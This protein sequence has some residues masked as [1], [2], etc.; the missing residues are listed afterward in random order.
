MELIKL[1][2]SES[3]QAFKL[4]VMMT[5]VSGAANG[6]L[7]GLINAGAMAVHSDT[8]SS[9]DFILFVVGLVLY[10]YSK[11]VSENRGKKVMEQ[12]MSK[13]RLRIYEKIQ[14]ASLRTIEALKPSEVI[15]KTSRNISQILQSSDSVIYGMQSLMMLIFCSIY[16]CIISPAAFLVVMAGVGFL[17]VLRYVRDSTRKQ[18]HDELI[19]R[20]GTQSRY[21]AD[22]IE[23]FKEVKV[24]H[25]KCQ[26]LFSTF[27]AAVQEARGLSMKIAVQFIRFRIVMQAAFYVILATVVFILPRFIDTFSRQVMESTSVVLFIVGYLSGFVE[28]I[29]VFA[30]TNAALKNIAELEAQLDAEVEVRPRQL[31]P[32]LDFEK[33][34]VKNLHFAYQDQAGE[35][36]FSVGPLTLEIER[37]EILFLTGGNGSGK[38]TLLKVLTGL[39]LPDAGE[40]TVDNVVIDPGNVFCLRELYSVIFTDFHL[41][42]SFYGYRDVDAARVN[43]L[44]QTMRLGDKVRFTDGAFST[45]NLSTGQRKRLAL[46]IALIEDRQIY[47][48]DEWAAD[49]DQYFRRYF[50]EGILHELKA[51]GKTV[52][53]VTHDEAYWKHADRVVKLDAGVVV[54]QERTAPPAI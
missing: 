10:L 52:I 12:A 1:F 27:A 53:A 26:D 19:V 46:I 16:L 41:F 9:R 30:R 50:Y 51:R 3:S 4:I 36:A 54:R 43:A 40:I 5:V 17:I 49:Q 13:Q 48:F 18:Q 20:E 38:S 7:V 37:G 24:N 2:K 35:Q 29:P 23:G 22:L 28:V 34:S 31:K 39:Y 45:L 33:I 6:A 44:I 11:D 15:A 47:V 21:M 42:D 8:V 32:F 25:A 14:N